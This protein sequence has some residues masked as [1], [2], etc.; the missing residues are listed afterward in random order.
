MPNFNNYAYLLNLNSYTSE[1]MFGMKKILVSYQV[2]K[3]G[4]QVLEQHY[5]LTY[6]SGKSFTYEEVLEMIG[7][8]DGLMAVNMKVDQTLIDQG[9]NLQIIANY[10]AGYDNIDV[11]YATSKGIVVTNTPEA[12]T[13]ATA[14]IA[15]GLMLSLTRNITYCD[16]K[17]RHDPEFRWGMLLQHTGHSLYGKTLGIIGMGRIGRAVARR[18][19]ASKMKIIYHNRSPLFEPFEREY[20]AEYTSMAALLK[21]ADIVS[22]HTPLTSHTRH[23]IGRQELEMMK[24]TAYL[25]N[26]ARGS[27][28]DEQALVAHLAAG[29]LAGAGLDVFENEPHITEELLRMDQVVL[30]PH[31]GTETI[32]ARTDMTL[33]AAQNLIMFFQGKTPRN[34]VKAASTPLK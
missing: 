26:T 9:K 8:Y 30:T 5:Q 18:A 29:K 14:E 34:V 24:P 22:I 31:I 12:V 4:L 15:F 17:L 27:V 33:E 6:P 20:E 3:E 16:H 28:I 19:V 10:G 1:R 13:E 25:I 7:S 23:M 2:P 32:E 11:A 21:T